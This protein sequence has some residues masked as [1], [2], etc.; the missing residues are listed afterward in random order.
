MKENT[1]T[2]KKESSIH[3]HLE[4]YAKLTRSVKLDASAEF[5][6]S[7]VPYRGP[8]LKKFGRYFVDDPEQ[9][10]RQL[11]GFDSLEIS[12]LGYPRKFVRQK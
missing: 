2:F 12:G 10:R 9:G 11:T 3:G 7:G 5:P 6:D 1:V 8:F 4:E